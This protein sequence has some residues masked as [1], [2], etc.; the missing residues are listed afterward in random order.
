M[1]H[2]SLNNLRFYRETSTG[3]DTEALLLTNKA[4]SLI[5]KEFKLKKNLREKA[6]YSN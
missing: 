1:T 6:D 5:N 3:L 4:E 2:D